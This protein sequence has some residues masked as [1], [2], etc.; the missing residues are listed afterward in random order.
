M[1]PRISHLHKIFN[2][3]EIST[4]SERV[5]T[6]SAE[7]ET[8]G[9]A[10][11]IDIPKKARIAL[12]LMHI[13]LFSF[14]NLFR[15]GSHTHTISEYRVNLLES[16]ASAGQ[17]HHIRLYYVRHIHLSHEPTTFSIV[18]SNRF[19]ASPSTHIRRSVWIQ[20]DCSTTDRYV[21]G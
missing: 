6:G 12:C 8:D 17:C 5:R 15:L 21:D 13:V 20:P 2:L 19:C 1:C 3:F 16:V 7:W 11:D 14:F 10:F 9:N 4:S 18:A